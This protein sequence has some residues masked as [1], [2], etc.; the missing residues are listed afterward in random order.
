MNQMEINL[1]KLEPRD[2]SQ[3]AALANNKKI[4][5]FV[6]DH[7]PHPYHLEDAV[8]FIE[9]KKDQEKDF[10]FAI[11]ADGQ[12]SGMIGLHPQGD[13]YRRSL[14]LGYWIGEPYW[15]RGIASAAVRS[16]LEFGFSQPGIN[17]IF[18]GVLETN[19][20]SKRVLEKNG[21]VFEGIARKAAWK[22]NVLLDEWRYGI[23]KE[24]SILKQD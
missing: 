8:K 4:W 16:I 19:A 20:G 6:R 24:E 5:D 9:L 7:M 14:E 11:E 21:F 10:V 13:I 23:L 2:G 3:L 17:R 15:G 22:N 1:R 18:A 12:F